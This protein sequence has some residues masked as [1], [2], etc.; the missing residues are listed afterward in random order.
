MTEPGVYWCQLAY[1]TNTPYGD[2]PTGRYGFLIVT[3]PWKDNTQILQT[4]VAHNASDMWHRDNINK[5][6]S[7][8]RMDTRY[9]VLWSNASPTSEFSAQSLY[10]IPY[11]NYSHIIVEYYT[12]TTWLHTL[13]EILPTDKNGALIAISNNQITFRRT[14]PVD[15][16]TYH[17]DY[18]YSYSTANVNSACVPI[19]ILGLNLK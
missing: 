19:R 3:A 16:T 8:H 14:T 9:T 13:S 15:D 4:Y 18:S 12:D 17:F 7:W 2:N 11:K 1:C 6:N 10:N 5:W